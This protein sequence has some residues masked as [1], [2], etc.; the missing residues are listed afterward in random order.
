MATVARKKPHPVTTLSDTEWRIFLA[1]VEFGRP[2][3]PQEVYQ[4]VRERGMRFA[5][6]TLLSFLRRMVNKGLVKVHKIRR[7][8]PARR[9]VKD[10]ELQ[11]RRGLNNLYTPLVTREKAVRARI[12]QFLG[13]AL[14]GDPENLELLRELVG[15]RL[16]R[17]R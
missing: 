13:E 1:L 8:D 15:D 7:A 4:R 5:Y 17:R 9:R 16:A 11:K 3:T 2:A 12:E 14:A 6:P 10:P